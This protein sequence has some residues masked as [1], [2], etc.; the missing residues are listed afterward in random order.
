[1]SSSTTQRRGGSRV[2]AVAGASISVERGQIVGLVG[3]SRLRQVD[4]RAGRGR[5]RAARRRGSSCSR[6]ARSTPLARRARSARPR[7]PSA[8]VP[9]PV[10]VAQPSPE[11]RLA[12]RRRARHASTSS[13][14]RAG[15][16]RVAGA[17]RAGRA[18]GDRRRVASRT[19]SRGGQR[20]R[21]AIAR[22]LAADPSVLVLDEPLASL[23][24]SA[25]AQLAN[26]LVEPLARARR[27]GLLL[28]S[29]DLAIVRHVADAVSVMYLGG[30]VETGPDD[31]ALGAAAPP[32]QRGA[33]Q[34]DPAPGRAAASCP[35]SLPGEVPDPGQPPTRLPLPPPLPVRVL[36][37]QRRGAAA[38][39]ARRRPRRGLLAAARGRRPQPLAGG[40]RPTC[41]RHR[42][43]IASKRLTLD[44]FPTEELSCEKTPQ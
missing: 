31:A 27:S 9:E 6:A 34:R 44:L 10:R 35:K 11:G 19:S 25:Q 28:I 24:A 12:A 37:L 7:S 41:R 39:D 36:A 8:R 26:L 33:D 23:D 18:P 15:A 16:A 38:R 32:V 1:M 14:R 13:R 29:H 43:R 20:Q 4:A 2:R 40:A 3:E 22:T 42:R 5:A 17:A 30:M 21:I